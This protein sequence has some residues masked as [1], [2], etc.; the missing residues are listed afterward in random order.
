[1]N[2]FCTISTKSHLFKCK[3][4]SD[5]LVKQGFEIITL[6]VDVVSTEEIETILDKNCLTLKDLPQSE[7]KLILSKYG[8]DLDKL[9]WAL[10]PILLKYLLESKFGKVIYVDNDIF[11]FSSPFSLF[12]Q[13]NSSNILLTPHYYLANPKKNQNW[14]EANLRVGLYN[15][16]FIGVNKNALGMLNWWKECCEFNVK[17]SFWRGLFDDQKYLDLVPIIF[18]NVY[19]VKNTGCN[20]AGWNYEHRLINLG[21]ASLNSIVF[22]HFADI[23]LQKFSI[24]GNP[25]H[26]LYIE[27]IKEIKKINPLFIEVPKKYSKRNILAFFY[28]MLWKLVRKFE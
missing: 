27:Y 18:D 19:I 3:V 22:V 26:P 10:K 1:M 25:F 11:F 9:R 8:S 13:L 23:T 17:K 5:S 6:F 7:M 20:L 14:L 15:A 2:C 21:D 24:F 4:L 28:F 16:G 12:D